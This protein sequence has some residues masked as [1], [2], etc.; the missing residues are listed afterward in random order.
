MNGLADS[1]SLRRWWQEH[2]E[3]D[4]LV[5]AVE[6]M[7]A[8]GRLVRARQAVADLEGVLDAHFAAEERVYFPLIERLSPDHR[9]SVQAASGSH[10]KIGELVD[11]LADLVERGQLAGARR[12]LEL[13]LERFRAH[14]SE[15]VRLIEDL[16]A[17]E[18][19]SGE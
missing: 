12:A 1:D 11:G 9:G 8:S 6:E 13:L 5:E 4:G 19:L 3:L 10:R 15:E 17:L 18:S 16:E 7:L 14:E 2:S